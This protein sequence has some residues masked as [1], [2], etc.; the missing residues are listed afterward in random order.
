M[1]LVD[2]RYCSRTLPALI[3]LALL[4][5]CAGHKPATQPQSNLAW[6]TGVSTHDLS[7][8]NLQRFKAANIECV[9]VGLKSLMVGTPE[10]QLTTCRRIVADANQ[11]GITLWSVHIPFGKGWDI[12][13]TDPAAQQQALDKIRGALELCRVLQPRKAV[14]HGSAEPIRD[15]DRA[16]RLKASRRALAQLTPEFAA[17]GIQLALEDLPRTCLG[18]TSDEV[19]ELMDGIPGLGVCFDTNH[20]LKETPQEFIRKVGARIV[21]I[22]ASDY[23]GPD[24]R[25]WM[26][27]EGINDWRQI[28][29]GLRAVGYQGPFLFETGKHRDGS[30]IQDEEYSA[31]ARKHL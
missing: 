29:N 18:N 13:V 16:A 28:V 4:C 21:T 12:S 2:Y 31:F 8:S 17:L 19:L 25:H 5:G 10:E 20:L 22:H 7:L 9:E 30:P 11:T 14:I 23:D 24:E 26:P 3:G 27:G 1:N 15:E 6:K